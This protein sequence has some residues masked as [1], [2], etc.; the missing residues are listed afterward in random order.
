MFF[1]TL[2]LPVTFYM[3]FLLDT[4]LKTFS[5]EMCQSDQRIKLMVCLFLNSLDS[6]SWKDKNKARNYV[7]TDRTFPNGWLTF[8]R[9][10][11]ILLL[12][13]LYF[14][15]MA[16]HCILDVR[17][18]GLSS[19][20]EHQLEFLFKSITIQLS[21]L[22]LASWLFIASENPSKNPAVS[23]WTCSCNEFTLCSDHSFMKPT[24]MSWVP[25]MCQILLWMIY[26]Y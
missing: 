24:S 11:S 3:V 2:E 18:R 17:Q 10:N 25:V 15:L 21:C 20:P 16:C 14:W 12:K 13:H 22:P 4:V 9:Q 7:T 8:L 26:I 1:L 23:S 6:Y 19:G 5:F